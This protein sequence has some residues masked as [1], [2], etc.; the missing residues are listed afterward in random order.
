MYR[1]DS[2]YEP[3]VEALLAARSE[4]KVDGWMAC[5]AFWLGRQQIYNVPDYW[6][7]L[8]AKIT[9]GLS[10]AD[11]NTIL[12]Q[13]SSKEAALVSSAVDW[14]ETPGSLLA[15]V[16]GWSP[17]P[18]PVDLYA[19]AASKRYAVE[20][21]GI[22]LNGMR[23]M[24]DRASQSLITG[25]YNYVQA[26][27]DVLVKFKTSGGFVELTAAQMTT[28]ANA[29]GA[30]VQAAFAAESDVNVQIIAGMITTKAGVDAFAWP[31]DAGQSTDT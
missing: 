30:H 14:P 9:S 2:M 22:L 1:I 28:I 4:N 24:T 20:T 27:P 13:L 21:G 3:M 15:I 5:V 8:A 11:Q 31:S 7:A 23:V 17:E 16:S 18:P 12:D 26:N 29:V 10:D 25:A 6:L 19:Y